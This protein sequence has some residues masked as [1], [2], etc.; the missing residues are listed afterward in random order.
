MHMPRPE[1]HEGIYHQATCYNFYS[2]M[3]VGEPTSEEK[4]KIF[5]EALGLVKQSSL[6]QPSPQLPSYKCISGSSCSSKLLSCTNSKQIH[7]SNLSLTSIPI[8]NPTCVTV[9]IENARY[10]SYV[11]FCNTTAN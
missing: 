9:C 1:D 8:I 2:H 11:L 10:S 6:Q 7:T 3:Y 4:A 5:V